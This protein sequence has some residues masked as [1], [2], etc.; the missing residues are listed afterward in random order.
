MS[1]LYNEHLARKALA[2]Y[3]CSGAEQNIV[4]KEALKAYNNDDIA[5][6]AG[7]FSQVIADFLE[8]VSDRNPDKQYTV[9]LLP[10]DRSQPDA[11]GHGSCFLNAV[12]DLL[13]YSTS[14]TKHMNAGT[15]YLFHALAELVDSWE[16][17][18]ETNSDVYQQR[19]LV[20][21]QYNFDL[22]VTMNWQTD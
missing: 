21:P 15:V 2:E 13:W 6:P 18:E 9:K 22:V 5:D 8:V 20:N 19:S 17:V 7:A 11:E 12:A 4:I 16:Q 14:Q 3:G 10:M 1:T